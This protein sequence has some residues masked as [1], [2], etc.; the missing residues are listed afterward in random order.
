MILCQSSRDGK[1][2]VYHLFLLFVHIVL[3]Y[4]KINEE[5]DKKWQRKKG[6]SADY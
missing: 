5:G 6:S 4:H 3:I 1:R 2:K